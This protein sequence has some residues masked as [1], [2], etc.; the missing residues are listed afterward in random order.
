[1]I[2]HVLLFCI[3]ANYSESAPGLPWSCSEPPLPCL[4]LPWTCFGSGPDLIKK[5]QEQN[6]FTQEPDTKTAQKQNPQN[7][8]IKKNIFFNNKTK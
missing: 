2:S 5:K 3:R 8:C 6:S 7:I 1:M 4:G